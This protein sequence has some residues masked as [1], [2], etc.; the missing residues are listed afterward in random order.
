MGLH[1]GTNT[2]SG[3]FSLSASG[4][5]IENGKLGRPVEQ[6]TIAGNFYRLLEAIED[7]ANDMYF[8]SGGKGSPSILVRGLDIAGM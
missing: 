6:I 8:S 4:F 2:V 1:A 5:L 3:D 7:V